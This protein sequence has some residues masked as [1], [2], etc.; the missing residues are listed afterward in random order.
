M[1]SLIKTICL[2]FSLDILQDASHVGMRIH[3]MSYLET[4]GVCKVQEESQPPY[5]RI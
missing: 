3:C 5:F 2:K 1:Q 4:A